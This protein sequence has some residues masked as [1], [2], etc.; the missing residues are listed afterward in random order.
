MFEWVII[1]WNPAKVVSFF[2]R[3]F[4]QEVNKKKVCFC[5]LV[6]SALSHFCIFCGNE[7]EWK[8]EENKT[9]KIM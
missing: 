5:A 1:S 4:L 2:Y 9:K 3:P 7:N 6:H 8:E